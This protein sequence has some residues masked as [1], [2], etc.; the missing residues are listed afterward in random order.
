MDQTE[1][2]EGAVGRVPGG[3]GGSCCRPGSA[4]GAGEGSEVGAG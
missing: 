2:H 1:P 4:L 3:I